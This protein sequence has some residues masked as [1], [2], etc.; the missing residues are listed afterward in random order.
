VGDGR[1]LGFGNA[2]PPLESDNAGDA[3]SVSPR[4]EVDGARGG[5]AEGESAVNVPLMFTGIQI[6]E[7]RIFDYIPRGVFSHTTVDVYPQAIARGETIAAHVATGNWYELSTIPRYLDTSIALMR[8]EQ[9]SVEVGEGSVS[10]PGAEVEDTVLWENAHVE[11]GARVRR[12]IL[13]AGVRVG[14]G[15][16]LED[17]AV[18]RA[19]LVENSERPPKALAGER[20]GDNFVVKLPR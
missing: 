11:S 17:V 4:G 6:L 18:V 12:A 9:R 8:N 14:A 10:E 5:D 19:Q 15:E 20:R 2:P 3:I 16:T 1:V 7:P 13:G